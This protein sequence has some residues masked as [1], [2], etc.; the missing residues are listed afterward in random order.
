ME[1]EAVAQRVLAEHEAA[2]ELAAKQ[3][4]PRPSP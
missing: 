4:P 3:G 1:K 2:V